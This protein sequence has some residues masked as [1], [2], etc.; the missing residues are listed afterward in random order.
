VKIRVEK[1]MELLISTDIGILEIAHEVGF[2]SL[3]TFYKNFKMNV[4]D[5]PKEYRRHNVPL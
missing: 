2:K 5:T 4:G 1:S 3:S